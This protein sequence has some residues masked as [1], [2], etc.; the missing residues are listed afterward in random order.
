MS[1]RMSPCVVVVGHVLDTYLLL[2]IPCVL[3]GNDDGTLPLLL[4]MQFYMHQM[5]IASSPD[6]VGYAQ[7]REIANSNLCED[8]IKGHAVYPS[9]RHRARNKTT[10]KQL[11]MLVLSH[12]LTLN[13]RN[14]SKLQENIWSKPEISLLQM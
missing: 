12:L 5:R 10:Y 4:L 11:T 3:L 9:I 8:T 2:S 7:Q 14:I 13:I 6:C 1:L